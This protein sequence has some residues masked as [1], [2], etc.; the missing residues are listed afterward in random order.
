MSPCSR[1]ELNILVSV[2]GVHSYVWKMEN[3]YAV[4]PTLF[5]YFLGIPSS[6][7]FTVSQ[8]VFTVLVSVIV[9]FRDF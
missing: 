1:E 6:H 8:N 2:I 5:G 9:L 4:I 3:D 7:V